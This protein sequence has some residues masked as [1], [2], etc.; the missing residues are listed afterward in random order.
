VY[1]IGRPE[2][3]MRKTVGKRNLNLKDIES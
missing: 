2:A 1:Q 3:P